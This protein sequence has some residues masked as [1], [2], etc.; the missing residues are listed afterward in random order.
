MLVQRFQFYFYAT[1]KKVTFAYEHNHTLGIKW[2]KTQH[3]W[4]HADRICLEG[5][6]NLFAA[7][8]KN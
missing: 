3:E 8:D 1:C 7:S 2:V 5:C 6:G 4:K